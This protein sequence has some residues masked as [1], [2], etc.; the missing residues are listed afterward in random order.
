MQLANQEAQRFNHEYIGTEHLLLGLIREGNALNNLNINLKKVRKQVQNLIQSGPEMI[1]MGKLPQTPRAKKVIESAKQHAT[2]MKH[3][4]IGTEHLILGLLAVD[5]GVAAQVL[6]NMGV[7]LEEVLQEVLNLL[8]TGITDPE[9]ETEKHGTGKRLTT[10][11]ERFRISHGKNRC[12]GKHILAS[13]K[14]PQTRSSCG[15]LR[16]KSKTVSKKVL[17]LSNY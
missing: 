14:W 3:H 5:E 12:P 4:F 8:G 6:V 10:Q 2:N 1:T 16:S 15:V 13:F 11:T 7:R 9:F 17:S